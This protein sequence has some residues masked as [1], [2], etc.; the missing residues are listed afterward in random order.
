MKLFTVK[1]KET[2][3]FVATVAANAPAQAKSEVRN[4]RYDYVKTQTKKPKPKDQ[5]ISLVK[6]AGDLKL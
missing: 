1:W 4:G 6:P 5:E 3:E 2:R